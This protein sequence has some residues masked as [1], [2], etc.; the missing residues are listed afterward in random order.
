MRLSGRRF[1]TGVFVF[2]AAVS[3]YG[4]VMASSPDMAAKQDASAQTETPTQGPEDLGQALRLRQTQEDVD[5]KSAGCQ[6]C[7][8]TTDSVT[9]HKSPSVRIGCTDCHGGDATVRVEDDI[10]PKSVEYQSAKRRAHPQ[11]KVLQ[12]GNSANP[13]RAYT[14]W[15]KE[16]SDYIRF[17]NPG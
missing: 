6:S 17:L 13:V 4:A 10:S 7:H 12:S 5:A 11:P 3:F 9:M 14:D 16:D 1:L 15:L 8:T 2:L